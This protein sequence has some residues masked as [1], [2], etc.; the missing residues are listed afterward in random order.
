MLLAH[1]AGRR[2]LVGF[3]TF[4]VDDYG[5][6][7]RRG[8]CRQGGGVGSFFVTVLK[9]E[10]MS[11]V[12]SGVRVAHTHVLLALALNQHS[13]ALHS[14]HPPTHNHKLLTTVP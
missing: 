8:G 4:S 7:E 14:L 9:L 2:W 5:I 13:P 3:G 10:I 1:N 12:R 11:G 6:A